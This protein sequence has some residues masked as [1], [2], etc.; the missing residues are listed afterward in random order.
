MDISDWRA[1][2][3]RECRREIGLFQTAK[4]FWNGREIARQNRFIRQL[5]DSGQYWMHTD[6]EFTEAVQRTGL[7]V[8]EAKTVYR[9]YSDLV[10]CQ[11][12]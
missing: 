5:Q 4:L 11:K 10:I 2:L 7:K 6:K 9:G 1:Y 8:L 12:E 3:F